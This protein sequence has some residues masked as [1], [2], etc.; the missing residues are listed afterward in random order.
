MSA[1]PVLHRHRPGG[2]RPRRPAR[3]ASPCV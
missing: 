3:R 1:R 2:R